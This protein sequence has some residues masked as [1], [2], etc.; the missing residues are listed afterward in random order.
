MSFTLLLSVLL[1]F[2]WC[3]PICTS[4]YTHQ[5]WLPQLPDHVSCWVCFLNLCRESCQHCLSFLHI[6]SALL[7]GHKLQQQAV[8]FIQILLSSPGDYQDQ[9]QGQPVNKHCQEALCNTCLFHEFQQKNLC[10]SQTSSC[11]KIC[12]SC[13]V[14]RGSRGCLVNIPRLH[15]KPLNWNPWEWDLGLQIFNKFAR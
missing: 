6:T 3:V 1:F 8:Q 10:H 12:V 2:F 11:G 9:G 15:C 7:S 13:G 4:C 14:F 5:C